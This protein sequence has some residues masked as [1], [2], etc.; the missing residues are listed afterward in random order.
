MLEERK[1]MKGEEIFEDWMF[2]L[3]SSADVKR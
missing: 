2:V 1:L 3:E